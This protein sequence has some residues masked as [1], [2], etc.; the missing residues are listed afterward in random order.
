MT[1]DA[2]VVVRCRRRVHL[3]H[4]PA[5]AGLP[6]AE[7]DP[8]LEQRRSDSMA[9][10]DELGLRLAELVAP[11]LADA[12]SDAPGWVA[13]SPG[14]GG[15]RRRATEEAMAAGAAYVWNGQ[16]PA[17]GG[18]RGD[19]DLLV[20]VGGA[21]GAGAGP[22]R[23]R[24]LIVVRHRISDPGSGALTSPLSTPHAEFAVI[25]GTRRARS[26]P[27]DQLRLAHLT[28]MLESAGHAVVDEPAFGAVI[29]M[30]ADVVVWHELSAPSWPGGHSTLQEYDARFA[31]RLAVAGAALTGQPALAQPSRVMECRRCPWWPTCEAELTERSDVSLVLRGEDAAAARSVGVT[32]VAQLAALDPREEPPV[33]L[34]GS[35]YPDAVALAR[36]WLR[37]LPVVRR[38][39]SV[40]VPRADVEVDIDMESFGEAGAYLWGALLSVPGN[41]APV[42]DIGHAPGYHAFATWEPLPTDDEARSFA[43]FWGWLG[44]IRSRCAELGLSFAAYCYNEQAENRW[45]LGSADRF[46]GYPGMPTRDE[47]TEF[48]TSECWVDMFAL[49]SQSFLC[50]H[51]KGL[52]R[53]APVAGFSWADP[54]ASGENSMRWYRDA[55]AMDGGRPC[56]VQRER[57]LRY[58]A[59]DVHA[60]RVLREWMCSPA[61]AEIPLAAEL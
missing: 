48:I 41:G 51:G 57:L 52:K 60:T 4:D 47:V 50:A 61:L 17:E 19:V 20:R 5:A 10:R 54:E 40:V 13:V 3:D 59:D 15:D 26:H 8:A 45:M 28:R 42:P 38:V 14:P 53:I 30:D 7:P 2:A 9:H 29:G 36:A 34:H 31:D 35:P 16:L 55:V 46:A 23:Y 43:E 18:R 21:P 58:N 22:A 6:R 1:L 44:S 37:G 49:V 39:P 27:R 12:G 56:G 25:D 11:G 32:T 33:P 24:P